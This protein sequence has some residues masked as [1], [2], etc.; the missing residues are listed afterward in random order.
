[1][2][3]RQTNEADIERILE[4]FEHGRQV[5]LA[6]GNP[7]QWR[8]GH[9][10]REQVMKDISA[11]FSYVCVIDETDDTDLP[12]GT[13]VATFAALEGE[14]PTYQEIEG[15]WLND[16]NYVT[17]HRISTSGAIK[18]TGQK[19][20]QWVIDHYDNIKIDTHH[21]NQPMIHV[22]EKFGFKYCGVIYISDGTARNAYQYTRIKNG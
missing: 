22:I 6:T 10:G 4:I 18:G 2:K 16:A 13:V 19:C 21:L 5:Q 3:I 7:N 8:K 1:M 11:G 9:P 17:I 12:L 20:M 14:D 15:G